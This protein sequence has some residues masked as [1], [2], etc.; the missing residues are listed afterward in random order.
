[1]F[2]KKSNV[3][4]ATSKTV[5][6]KSMLHIGKASIIDKRVSERKQDVSLPKLLEIPCARQ[7]NETCNKVAT[8]H[9]HVA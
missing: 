1:M 3:S 4:I 2:E 9:R 5:G 6:E 7:S 8:F